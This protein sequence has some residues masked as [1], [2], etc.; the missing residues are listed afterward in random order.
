MDHQH[1]A[2]RMADSCMRN[3]DRIATRI[4]VGDGWATQTFRRLDERRRTLAAHLVALGVE[5]GDRVAIFSSNRPEWSEVDLACLSVRA[6]SV[7]LYATSTPDQARHIMADSGASV[8]VVAG[9]SE[10][11]RLARVWHELPD[12]RTV[13]T[14][15][16]V[17]PRDDAASGPAIVAYA[18]LMGRRPES[19]HVTEVQ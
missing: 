18:D 7:P 5:P 4:R 10:I 8:V 6:V 3:G 16:P 11:E 12:L 2:V 13:V 1:L 17:P 15:D 14:F 9:A 19:A